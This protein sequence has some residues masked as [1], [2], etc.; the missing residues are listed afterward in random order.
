M[1]GRVIATIGYLMVAVAALLMAIGAVLPIF[2]GYIMMLLCGLAIGSYGLKR[3]K[4]E[5]YARLERERR[6]TR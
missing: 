3:D 1:S 5:T 6:G 4:V 2:V